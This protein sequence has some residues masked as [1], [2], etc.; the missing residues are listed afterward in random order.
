M[1]P[2][3]NTK[4][5]VE[6]SCASAQPRNVWFPLI[7][8]DNVVAIVPVSFRYSVTGFPATAMSLLMIFS[9]NRWTLMRRDILKDYQGPRLDQEGLTNYVS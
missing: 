1:E 6:F 5:I 3:S 8:G 7:D 4:M 9:I 2:L